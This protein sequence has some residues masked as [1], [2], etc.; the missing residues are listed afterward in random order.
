MHYIIMSY[1]KDTI[2]I[3]LISTVCILFS[4]KKQPYI[5]AVTG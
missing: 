3:Y 5:T 2:K 4:M 1:W